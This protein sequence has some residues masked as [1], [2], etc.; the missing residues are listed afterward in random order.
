MSDHDAPSAERTLARLLLG[1]LPG[2]R[3]RNLQDL[4]TAVLREQGARSPVLATVNATLAVRRDL[5]YW[6]RLEPRRHWS[7]LTYRPVPHAGP[8][9][10]LSLLCPSRGRVDNLGFFL[11][12]LHRTAVKPGRVEV[13]V[14]V[15]DDDPAL[16]AYRRLFAR[17][18]RIWP[19]LG[20]CRLVVGPPEGVPQAWNALAAQACGDL[21][22]M[23]NDDQVYVDHGWDTTLD[24]RVTQLSALHGDDVLCLYFDD[25]QYTDGGRDFPIV[26]RTWH[27]V[28]GYFTP[29]LF[30]QWEVE[31]WVF[32]IALRLDRCHPVPGVFVEHRHYQDY[33][34]PFDETY[35]RHRMTREKS[36]ADHALFLSTEPQRAAEAERLRRV[37]TSRPRRAFTAPAAPDTVLPAAATVPV[38]PAAPLETPGTVEL[39]E[40]WFTGHLTASRARVASEATAWKDRLTPGQTPHTLPLWS[41]GRPAPGRDD[42]FPATLDVLASIPEIGATKDGTAVLEW[43]PA[44]SGAPGS[45]GSP[46]RSTTLLRLSGGPDLGLRLDGRPHPW[47]ADGCVT[48]PGS[49]RRESRNDGP[50]GVLLLVLNTARSLAD[51]PSEG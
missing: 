5:A 25:G 19:R 6:L 16:P 8:D 30:Q 47:P 33:K 27:D 9:R 32:D 48:V 29:T 31:R 36:L 2:R 49:V 46:Q 10:V 17:A 20:E 50:D 24:N 26:S 28:L 22:M 14:Y 38:T 35:Q 12:S 15:D 44:G 11:R 13:M 4:A 45:V 39:P 43:W 21:L 1:H 42:H 34:A 37:M 41:E 40:P 18:A 51:G 23:A 3:D 7:R